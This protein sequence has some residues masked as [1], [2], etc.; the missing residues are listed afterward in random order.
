M[1][2][3]LVRW[4]ACGF[5]AGRVPVA[6]GLAGSVVGVGYW[7]VL[8]GAGSG[9]LYAMVTLAGLGGAVWV[10]GAAARAA[11]EHDPA[12]VVIDE[13]TAVPVALAASGRLPAWQIALGLVLFRVFDVW[14]PFPIR[15]LQSWP[16]GWGIVADDV[17]AAG[18]AWVV[19]WAVV[20]AWAARGR[21]SI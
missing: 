19:R 9:W 7:W 8:A 17:L 14:K 1:P 13:L 3:R 18:Y 21:L 11:G 5:G 16:A 15:R 2:E 6:P 4:L 12:W 20:T 10:A